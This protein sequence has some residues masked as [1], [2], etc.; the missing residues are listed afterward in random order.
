MALMPVA[1]ALDLVL[2]GAEPLPPEQ[3]QLDDALGRILA[4]DLAALRTQPPDAMSAMDGYAVRAADVAAT[5]ATL[6]VI[7]EVAAG[8]PFQ[9]SVGPGQAARIFTGGVVPPGADAIVI[10]ENTTRRGRP[11][12]R[13]NR[14]QGRASH[15]RRRARFQARRGAAAQRPVPQRPRPDVGSGDEPS[16]AA[17]ASTAEARRHCDRRRI[18][19]ARQQSRTGRDRLFQRLRARRARA[20]RRR[21]GHRIWHRAG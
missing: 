2:Q 6:T 17:G 19:A 11:R 16:G 10:Q 15:P 13:D 14:L 21:T 7:G 5:P 1:E 12:H 3:V 20:H 4:D 9:G 8:H 18:G